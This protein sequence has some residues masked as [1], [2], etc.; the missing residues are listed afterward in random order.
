MKIDSDQIKQQVLIERL[1]LQVNALEQRLH[2]K[3]DLVE[4]VRNQR[5][6]FETQLL[7]L[8]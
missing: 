8:M 3:E 4:E 7:K 5:D 6:K 2:D 1:K